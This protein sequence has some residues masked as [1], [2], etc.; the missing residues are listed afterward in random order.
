LTHTS[1]RRR[2]LAAPLG[3]ALASLVVLSG[4]ATATDAA[5][6]SA[7]TD[8]K[9]GG[10]LTYLEYQA[11]TCFYAGGSG[12]YPV[13]SILNQIGD[14]L[15]Y[16]D[17]KTWE[18]QPWLAESWEVNADATEYVFHLRDGVTFS[19]GSVLDATAVAANF[20]HYGLGDK[21]LGLASQEFVS[22][23]VAS[24]V[25]DPLTVKFTFSRP[26][27]GF[28]QATSVVG[29]AIVSLETTQLPYEEQCQL[30][31]QVGSGPFTV[32]DV[33]PEEEYT[34]AV[35]ED[36][37]WAPASFDHQG[38]AYLDEIKIIVSPEDSV[39]IGALTS[40]QAD[41]IRSVQAYDEP[42]LQGA[43]FTVYPAQT[44]GVNPGLW[45]RASNPLLSDVRVREA[46]LK[47]TDT[48]SIV[49]TL[50]TDSYPRATSILSSKAPGYVDLSD[51]LE[52][53]PKG[54]RKLLDEAGWKAGADGIRT[55]D[56]V[57]LELATIVQTTIP[58]SQQTLELVAQQWQEIG[59]KLRV[60]LV[61]P[62]SVV[63]RA[64]D[65]LATPVRQAM[66]GRVDPDVLKS[67]FYSKGSRNVLLSNDAELDA[68]LDE[69][70]QLA[71]TED[72]FAKA[73]EV[74]NYLLDNAYG[75]PLFE[76]PQVFAGASYVKG[77]EFEPVGRAVFYNTW[78]SNQ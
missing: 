61:D 44:K 30:E 15:T 27:P 5:D 39:R 9:Y 31:N 25:V 60:D 26:S 51:K 42:A 75:I 22:N 48:Q 34:L 19:D 58:L 32:S 46:L 2:G 10:T 76:E 53:D 70:S 23:Y 66:V 72:R 52:Y 50:F 11:P 47:G 12:F 37:D 55:K 7:G 54:A 36:Y 73:A 35:R 63:T 6:T 20:D 16:Q 18:I 40:G 67:Q 13:A 77:S 68:L 64:A 33:V 24:E 62:A 59:V 14:K 29:A 41:F 3:I 4:C 28:L 71:A 1:S 21:E 78:K 57:P 49:D 69:V 65:P 43:G 56:G 45:L 38:R 8:P 74:Q 17:P